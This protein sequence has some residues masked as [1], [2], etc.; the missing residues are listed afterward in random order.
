M[1]QFTTVNLI[2]L[3]RRSPLSTVEDDRTGS[4]IQTARAN[5]IQNYDVSSYCQELAERVASVNRADK[6][7]QYRHDLVRKDLFDTVLGS[8][9][10]F[11]ALLK[12]DGPEDRLVRLHEYISETDNPDDLH[13]TL[14]HKGISITLAN[15]DQLA[16]WESGRQL[17]DIFRKLPK[18][19]KLANN[20]F[21]FA[22]TYG[23]KEASYITHRLK[24]V[25]KPGSG[26]TLMDVRK[27]AAADV[28]SDQSTLYEIGKRTAYAVDPRRFTKA[29]RK[30][31]NFIVQD[32]EGAHK[33]GNGTDIDP[34]V[35]EAMQEFGDSV[36][37]PFV[38]EPDRRSSTLVLPAST[39]YYALQRFSKK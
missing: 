15:V 4:D 13:K 30:L 39:V 9:I 26:M 14:E 27:R 34:K 37:E 23:S 20:G 2:D 16:D 12:K 31:V 24:V 10:P 18:S 33:N 35:L 11:L 6:L 22:D 19:K 29:Q 21:E 17:D 38:E 8:R 3:V 7:N 28:T 25:K 36:V 32:L 1:V 5:I